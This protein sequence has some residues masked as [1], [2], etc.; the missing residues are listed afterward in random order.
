[1]TKRRFR[2]IFPLL[3]L[4]AAVFSA[5]GAGVDPELLERAAAVTA[6]RY[7]DADSV[8][9]DDIQNVVYQEDGRAVETD[10]FY[11]KILTDA[12]RR[13]CREL[14][15][16][17]N[18]SYEKFT[19]P[20]VEVIRPDGTVLP[21]DVAANGREAVEPSQMG[22]N[23]YDPANKIF[24][25]TVSEL[26]I[27][28]ILHVVSRDEIVKPRVPDSWSSIF[29]LQSDVPILRYEVRINAPEDLPLIWDRY[30]K[31][32]RVHRMARMGTGLGLSIVK[33]ILEVHG[34]KYGV[35]STVGKGSVFWFEL[36]V[37]EPPSPEP[38]RA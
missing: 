25:V 32:D 33:G 20:T 17:Y 19:P 26:E 34:A 36:P 28:D 12:G 35:D 7:P 3:L 16:Y 27:G 11:Q 21:V 22:A 38:G 24:T 1:M 2:L 9:L 13:S 30:Y 23:I 18:V 6:E 29:V 14:T 8:L 37:S 15:F 31:V 5:P 10:D 4:F